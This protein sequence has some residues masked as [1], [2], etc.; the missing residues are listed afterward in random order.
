MSDL[1]FLS[2]PTRQDRAAI[3]VIL[4]RL[5]IGLAR[6]FWPFILVLLLQG[7]GG[8]AEEAS[9]KKDW[10]DQIFLYLAIAGG[11]YGAV[12]SIISYFRFYYFVEGDEF[13]IRKGVFQKTRKNVSF[14]RIQTIN[15][16]QNP[17]HR[18]LGVTG[19]EIDTAGS[20]GSEFSIDAVKSD[21]AEAI[22]DYLIQRK[23]AAVAEL[24][25]LE[26]P[27]E[28]L[29]PEVPK[30]TLLLHL[31]VGDLIKVGVSQNH[32]RTAFLIIGFFFGIWFNIRDAVGVDVE[33]Q[34]FN[35]I[36]SEQNTGIFE[37]YWVLVV[38]LLIIAFIVTL[39]RTVIRFYGLKVWQTDR[40]FKMKSGLFNRQEVSAN[41]QK[42]Q[43]VEWLRNPIRRLLGLYTV[44]MK[45]A[46]SV[47]IGKKTS[48]NVPGCSA[49]Q[50]ERVRA[51]YFPEEHQIAWSAFK[52]NRAIVW[53]RT[54]YL[55]TPIAVGL[56]A[57][58]YF[59]Y[60]NGGLSFLF[61]LLI[62]LGFLWNHLLYRKWTYEV[63]TE[64]LRVQRGALGQKAS[65]LR[66]E[67]VQG[68]ALAQS[69]YQRRNALA[70]LTLYTA[71]GSTKVIFVALATARQLADW[72]LYRIESDESPWM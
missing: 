43:T 71:A 27:T 8:E 49:S 70:D 23:R 59:A 50:L 21:Q 31:D 2:Q 47:S 28:D 7:G 32:I 18:M 40:G 44:R 17:I 53:R 16:K 41:L 6:T 52:P 45:Q 11:I 46:S 72:A 36:V 10:F 34:L 25:Q 1:T 19:I 30:Q 65:L 62:P 56:T 24:E 26:E 15:F 20:R 37:S 39:I 14:D 51:A 38:P 58:N 5:L 12:V 9:G 57:L 54:L 55:W 22:R 63:S 3:V 33:E 35:E 48:I 64:G 42:I 4:V 68:I 13:V 67:K 69:P 66:W 60:E 61:L 29:V